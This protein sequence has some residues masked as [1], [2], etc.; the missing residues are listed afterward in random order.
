MIYSDGTREW[1]F[2]G[3]LHREKNQPAVIWGDGRKEWFWYGEKYEPTS[4]ID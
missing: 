4:K 2:H 1:F 3:E